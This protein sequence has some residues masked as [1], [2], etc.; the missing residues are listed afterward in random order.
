[1]QPVAA[2]EPYRITNGVEFDH[3]TMG[4]QHARIRATECEADAVGILRH[5]RELV[6]EGRPSTPF[7]HVR[8][9]QLELLGPRVIRAAV[10]GRDMLHY[11][12]KEPV[13][14]LPTLPKLHGMTARARVDTLVNTCQQFVTVTGGGYPAVREAE[15]VRGE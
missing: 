14:S 11:F 4:M 13:G 8:C 9:V 6:S 7:R 15:H 5:A 12:G 2:R 1:M 10:L 3:L